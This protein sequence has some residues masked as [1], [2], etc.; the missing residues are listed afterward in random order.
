[1]LIYIFSAPRYRERHFTP[2]FMVSNRRR[3]RLPVRSHLSPYDTTF[4]PLRRR[5]GSHS[6]RPG[7][8]HP[9]A[10]KLSSAAR[11][12]DSSEDRSSIRSCFLRIDS[13]YIVPPRQLRYFSGTCAEDRPTSR[14]ISQE[15]NRYLLL[16]H[17][18]RSCRKAF[19]VLG[20]D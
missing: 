20:V 4:P 14:W 17:G 11:P 12:T 10:T 19:G 9:N 6:F 18:K 13:S 8:P 7:P 15:S 3:S 5:F 2:T 16:Q 1:M